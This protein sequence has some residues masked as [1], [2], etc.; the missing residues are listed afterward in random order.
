MKKLIVNLSE[1]T[2]EKLRFECIKEKK[3][4]SDIIAERLLFKEFDKEVEEA[5]SKF[6]EESFMKL[7]GELE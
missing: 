4:M 5:F 7:I 2:Y 3:E 1:S 6:C